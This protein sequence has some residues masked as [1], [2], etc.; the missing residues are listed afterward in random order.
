[1][2]SPLKGERVLMLL[3][4]PCSPD[5]RV[6]REAGALR[7]GGAE[8]FI[9]C[10]DREGSAAPHEVR[11]GATIERLH[12][13]SRRGVGVRQ[14]WPL[15]Q[16]YRRAAT[17]ATVLA[18]SVVHVHDLPLLPLGVYLARRLRVPLVYDAHEIYHVMEATKYPVF[19]RR[20]MAEVE[21][22]L[23]RNYVKTL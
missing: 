9:L 21:A 17:R 5:W 18:P 12:T 4:N 20:A 8:V 2:H 14:I 19:V 3:D 1:M 11:D 23:L 16:F 6:Q 7:D 10:W 22:F 15:A 13:P